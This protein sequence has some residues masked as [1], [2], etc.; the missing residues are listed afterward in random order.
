LHKNLT[1]SVKPRYIQLSLLEIS[2]N[3]KSIVGPSQTP[4]WLIGISRGYF[5]LG[6][7]KILLLQTCVLIP[8][9]APLRVYWV[10]GLQLLVG[11]GT[12]YGRP[13]LSSDCHAAC[14][15]VS[16]SPPVRPSRGRV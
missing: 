1:V 16:C 15:S 10:T 2:V 7:F 9:T 12:A 14:L 13:C 3:S 8:R 4:W 11:S 5:E 6:Y